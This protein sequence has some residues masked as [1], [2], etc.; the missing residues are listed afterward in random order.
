MQK[1]QKLL[2][3]EKISILKN[4]ICNNILAL[5][6]YKNIDIINSINFNIAN[7]SYEKLY[8]NLIYLENNIENNIDTKNIIES[9]QKVVNEISLL[10]MQYGSYNISDLISITIGNTY[11]QK[12]LIPPY[13]DKFFVIN[14]F[15]SPINYK[16][17]N[18]TNINYKQNNHE[19][20]NNETN[21]NETNNNETNNNETNNNETN[22]NEINNNEI[23]NNETNNNENCISNNETNNKLNNEIIYDIQYANDLNNNN[24]KNSKIETRNG[25]NKNKIV[26]EKIIINDADHLECLDLGRQ[27][28]I[29]IKKV[30]GINVILHDINNKRTLIVSCLS[31]NINISCINSIFINNC[32]NNINNNKPSDKQFI[33]E[34]WNNYFACLTLKDILIFNESQLYDK[35]I[36]YIYQI[37]ILKQNNINEII[38]D[39][40]GSD[41]FTQRKTLILLL[42]YSEN[43]DFK[44]IA[45]LLFDLLKN[46]NL[47]T[48]DNLEQNIIYN[49]LPYNCKKFFNDAIKET[50]K[51]SN[52]L[53]NFDKNK[54]PYEQQICLMKTSDYVKEKAMTKLKEIQ[55]KSDES[56]IKAKQF[57]EG[58]LKIPFGTYI[59]EEIFNLKYEIQNVFKLFLNYYKNNIYI[60]TKYN[61]SININKS[62][63]SNNEILNI[64]NYIYNIIILNNI[65]NNNNN[66]NNNN[67]NNNNDN[68]NNDNNDKYIDLALINNNDNFEEENIVND[69]IYN[70]L[71]YLFNYIISLFKKKKLENYSKELN[72]I[73]QKYNINFNKIKYSNKSNTIIKKNIYEFFDYLLINNLI[74]IINIILDN[75]KNELIKNNNYHKH[76]HSI[77]NNLITHNSIDNQN[78]NDSITNN[79]IDDNLIH[80]VKLKK[81]PSS[82]SLA[83]IASGAS[84]TN[85]DCPL[86]NSSSLIHNSYITTITN[87]NTSIKDYLKGVNKILD[88]SIYGHKKAK[89]QIERIIGQ[90]INGE[91]KGYC[92]GFEG[93]PGIGKTSL[94]NKGIANCLINA[95]GQSRPFAFI[96]IGGSSNSS[97]LDGHNYTYMGSTWGKLVDILM[98][99]KCM[100]P[101]IFIDE[102]DK[103][104]KTEH[105]KE[106]IGILTHLVDSTQNDTFQDKYFS[107]IDIDL[108]KVL[109][110]FSYNDVEKID[111]IL[112]DRI[113][114]I[115]FDHLTIHDKIVIVKQFLLPEMIKQIGFNNSILID[116]D[117]IIFLINNFTCESGVRKLKELLFEIV[118]QINLD[119]L[120]NKENIMIEFPI[121]INISKIK[122]IFNDRAFIRKVKINNQPKVG[123]VNGLWAN[124]VG[125]GGILHIETQFYLTTNLFDLKLTGMQGD[126]MKESMNVAKSLCYNLLNTEETK[127]IKNYFENTKNQGIHVHVPEGATPKDG[128]SAG[129]AITIAMYSLIINKKI[130]N[131][132]AITG[133]INL[134]GNVTSIGGLELKILGAIEAGVTNIIYPKDNNYH[135][136]LFLNKYNDK[137][138]ISNIKFFEVSTI[139]EVIDLVIIK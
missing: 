97:I 138:D 116:E 122:E 13:R 7:S 95:K 23:N 76:D 45:N 37:N 47:N 93:P 3:K 90:W 41:N 129:T 69:K 30:Y 39:F 12:L 124:S 31:T 110:I 57:L 102:I 28:Q 120:K 59:Y 101:I 107:G 63:Y 85:I 74:Y 36:G 139:Y 127:Y 27:T 135:F 78:N 42:L 131:L 136:K 8:T 19:T 104:S 89:L 40:I 112:L 20:N 133:E 66:I 106:I 123:V 103:V 24:Y 73:I 9:L 91:N 81:S 60:F 4:I 22:N 1:K 15:L 83:S 16:I 72:N 87:Y 71:I 10:I 65:N 68:D 98:E 86:K 64:I 121:I 94:A 54:I 119:L 108:S 88:E 2:I 21:N 77:N 92:F 18:W 38:N 126:V 34:T 43:N 50:I 130:N 99:K 17:I 84:K 134:Q 114:R 58:L 82:Q 52:K 79:S 105:G 111:K 109:F 113:H 48:I 6:K 80:N 67:N 96:A 26:D 46:E 128:P 53:S 49:S 100:N 11:L 55:S 51:Y 5:E 62:Y 33:I 137:I 125:Q 29:F 75:H 70:S 35:Y 115:K 25:I 132:F 32:I 44:Y 14:K 117:A 118:S 61:I 56:S